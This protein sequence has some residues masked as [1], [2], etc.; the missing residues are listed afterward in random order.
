MDLD[1]LQTRVSHCQATGRNDEALRLLEEHAEEHREELGWWVMHTAVLLNVEDYPRAEDSAR[2]ALHLEPGAAYAA[3]LL[4]VAL[5]AQ[6][7]RD[8]ALDL[9]RQVIEAEPNDPE[10]H[11]RHAVILLG[12][13][14]DG[15]ELAQARRSLDEALRLN[16][17]DPDAY[18]AAAVAADLASDTPA[19]LEYLRAGLALDPHHRGLLLASGQIDDAE[20]VVGERGSMLRGL[21]AHNPLDEKIHSDYAQSF[22]SR[23]APLQAWALAYIPVLALAAHTG[24]IR[25][26]PAAAALLIAPVLAGLFALSARRRWRQASAG[27][28]KGY[29][30][31]IAGKLPAFGRSCMAYLVAGVA[32]WCG[33]LLAV[34]EPTG[35]VGLVVLVVGLLATQLG[36][37]WLGV[38]LAGGPPQR[39]EKQERQ[40]YLLRRSGLLAGDNRRRLIAGLVMI[41][42][43]ALSMIE[44]SALSGII[45]LSFGLGLL[46]VGVSLAMWQL[47][48]GFRN[49]AWARGMA[50]QSTRRR[51][52]ASLRG[53]LV[54]FYY[55]GYHLVVGTVALLMGIGL[56][57]DLPVAGLPQGPKEPDT[58]KLDP[59]YLEQ[60]HREQM[61]FKLELPSPSPLP[62]LDLDR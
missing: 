55:V 16:P 5:A 31:D 17:E 11:Y 30:K 39:G 53:N 19:A 52:T 43:F 46:W 18:Q 37:Q 42:C 47:C 56:L 14:R 15:A 22:L 20:K 41:V 10:A 54:G 21:L 34:F 45:A 38:S 32:G 23:L 26:L 33:A 40:G 1:L 44:P 4:A 13:I 8:D 61:D 6:G 59:Q 24:A 57:A 28:P 49:N 3:L 29:L 25:A 36:G 7:R 2:R 58:V 62:S 50:L 9:S 12:D 27:M 51:R 48:L 35:G 60:L